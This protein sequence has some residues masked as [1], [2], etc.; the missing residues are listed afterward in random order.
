M[1]F[2]ALVFL[3]VSG[4]YRTLVPIINQPL[5]GC[6]Q[7]VAVENIFTDTTNLTSSLVYLYGLPVN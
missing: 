5:P 2:G 6:F 7:K 1:G 4:T 3:M